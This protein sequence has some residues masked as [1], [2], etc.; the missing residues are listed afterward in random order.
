MEARPSG[1]GLAHLDKYIRAGA[2]FN[3]DEPLDDVFR[4][5]VVEWAMAQTG[6]KYDWI[7]IGDLLMR[8]LGEKSPLLPVGAYGKYI[9][10]QLVSVGYTA[11]GRIMFPAEERWTISPRLLADRITTRAWETV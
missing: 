1:A 6:A 11:A 2:V 4:R 10:S 8:Q 7:A 9:C 3:D 5:N